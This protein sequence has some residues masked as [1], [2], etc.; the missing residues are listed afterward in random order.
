MPEDRRRAD[1]PSI[2]PDERIYI[3]IP[4]VGDCVIPVGDGSFRPSSGSLR[5]PN[6]DEPKSVDL[7]SLCTPEDTRHRGTDGNFHVVAISAAQVRASALRVARDPIA[8]ESSHN[9]AHALIVGSRRDAAGNYTGGLTQGE[10]SKLAHA[11]RYVIIVPPPE[12]EA[13]LV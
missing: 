7:G 6:P 10:Y 5:G 13:Q 8:N 11:A 2:P 12:G 3:R 4:A 1:D 9:P